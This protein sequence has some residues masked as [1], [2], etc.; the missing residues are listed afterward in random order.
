MRSVFHI[1]ILMFVSVDL[2]YF[3]YIFYLYGP[4][5]VFLYWFIFSLS[6]LVIFCLREHPSSSHAF[7]FRGVRVTGS[8]LLSCFVWPLCCMSFFNLRTVITPLVSS[9]SS[10]HVG[11][12]VIL[13]G[14]HITHFYNRSRFFTKYHYNWV[15]IRIESN[16]YI[17]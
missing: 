6:Q 11:E 17:H 10:Y 16:S 12:H 5:N 15:L 14:V 2:C 13:A 4:I 1:F 9:N 8:L 3:L 7:R